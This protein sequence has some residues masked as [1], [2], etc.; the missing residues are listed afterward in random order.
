[1][2]DLDLDLDLALDLGLDLL[3]MIWTGALNRN[4][5]ESVLYQVKGNDF[6]LLI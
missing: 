5:E 1:V 4:E 3:S 2:W 6:A